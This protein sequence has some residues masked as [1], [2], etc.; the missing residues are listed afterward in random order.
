MYQCIVTNFGFNRM[1]F[2]TRIGNLYIERLIPFSVSDDKFNDPQGVIEDLRVFEKSDKLGFEVVVDD[3]NGQHSTEPAIDYAERT[4]NE[5]RSIATG[6]G[7]KRAFFMKKA[8]L[9][10]ILKEEDN[11]SRP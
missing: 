3:E 11:E 1:A 2:P 6:R 8:E 10:K 4:I 9:I 5:L 7:V